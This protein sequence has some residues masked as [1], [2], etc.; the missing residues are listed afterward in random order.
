VAGGEHVL[1]SCGGARA[2][3]QRAQGLEHAAGRFL[4]AAA[5][6]AATAAAAAIRHCVRVLLQKA[7]K[8]LDLINI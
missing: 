2:L 6:A 8:D 1:F 5:P 3:Q 4:A 7:P